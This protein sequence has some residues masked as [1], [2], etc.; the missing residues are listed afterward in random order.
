[1]TRAA[2]S[3]LDKKRRRPTVAAVLTFWFAIT[4][5]VVLAAAPEVKVGVSATEVFMG[6]SIDFLVDIRNVQNP[7]PP[8]LSAFKDQFDVV[9][10]GD[11]SRDQTSISFING[12]RVA[13][14]NILSHI[15]QYRLTPKIAG[16]LTIPSAKVTVDGKT[17]SSEEVPL[18]VITSEETDVV[19]AEMKTSDARVYPTQPFTVTLKLLV[20]PLPE[21]STLDPL[22]PLQKQPPHLQ[23]SWVDPPA[24]LSSDDKSKWLQPLLADDS[25]GFTLNDINTRQGSFFDGPRAAV[26]NLYKGRESRP[27]LDGKEINYFVYELSRT[28]T[29]EKTGLYSLGPARVKGAFVVGIERREYRGKRLIVSAPAASIEVREV[30]SPRPASFVGGIGDY[31]IAASANPTRL[32]VGDPLTLTLELERGNHSGSLELVSAPNLAANEA[33]AADFDLI[34]KNPTGRIDGSIKRFAY[35]LRPKR[36]GVG[37]PPLEVVTFNP[38]T[39]EFQTSTIPAI[40]LEV[41]EADRLTS[42]EL[43]GTRSMSG[44]ATIKSRAEGIFQNVIDPSELRDQRTSL[45]E[46]VKAVVGVWCAAGTLIGI[47]VLRRR[48]TSDSTRSRRL[49]ARSIAQKRLIEA[50]SLA[51]NGDKKESLRRVR[52]ALVGLIAD[53]Q[54]RVAE[55]LTTAD[56]IESLK[57]APITGEDRDSIVQLLESIESAD[58]GA[59]E[60]TDPIAAVDDASKWIARVAP[61]LERVL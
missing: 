22:T 28:F 57:S 8:D 46:W 29:A 50:K 4:G 1:M 14:T 9:A 17:L 56:V 13:K 34:D 27:G 24:G 3:I 25:V 36:A 12:R 59:G 42:G 26:F 23:V 15:Y 61:R 6:D 7:P 47:G 52:A 40:P 30:P 41:A 45:I 38:Q 10:T 32:R 31:K 11:E 58:Y 43:V 54:N 21:D 48:M 5:T 49:Q 33:L 37:I 44:S 19:I 16:N 55:G 20:A 53:L 60:S 51:T 18:R 35:A 39:E 2:I